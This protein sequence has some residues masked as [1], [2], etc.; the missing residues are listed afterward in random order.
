MAHREG[1]RASVIIPVYNKGKF[2]KACF[3]TL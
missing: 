1:L 2:L 3:K